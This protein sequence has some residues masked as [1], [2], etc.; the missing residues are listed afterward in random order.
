MHDLALALVT[1]GGAGLLDEWAAGARD[2]SSSVA[3]AA[4]R[5]PGTEARTPAL[6]R[7]FDDL[8]AMHGQGLPVAYLRALAWHESRLDPRATTKRSSAT[9]LLQ[10]IDVVRSDHNRIHGTAYTREDLF[11]PVVNITIA[12]AAL[13]RII[14]SYARNH[15]ACPNL[16]EDWN[17]QHFATLVT[18]GWNAGWSERAGV[19]R[20]VGYLKQL[21]T[22]DIT[23]ELVHQHARAAGANEYLQRAD[24]LAWAQKVARQ[25]A[26]ERARDATTPG[27]AARTPP[28]HVRAPIDDAPSASAA[29]IQDGPV[30]SPSEVG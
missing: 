22:T 8:F 14:D 19:G 4:A 20:V 1:I 25:Y 12:A 17:N 27:V 9:G 15:R 6:P 26:A 24:R 28:M 23:A 11:D 2:R 10:I 16:V 18:L 30:R 29:A 13:R 21:G 5:R 7:T 3:V